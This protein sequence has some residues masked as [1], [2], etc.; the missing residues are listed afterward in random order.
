MKSCLS[1][2]MVTIILLAACSNKESI[3]SAD[4]V[5]TSLNELS[6]RTA[7]FDR[8]VL[9]VGEKTYVAIGFGLAN[10]IMIEGENS[11]VIIDAMESVQQGEEVMKVFREITQ[12]PI[13]KL[14]YTH[15]H[16]D[17]VFGAKAFVQ[18]GVTEVI[19]HESLPHYLNQVAS[20]VRPIIEKRS[21]RMFGNFLSSDEII[22]CGIG[23]HLEITEETLLSVVRPTR[24]FKDSLVITF[25]K[26]K[27]K[28]FHA[29]GETPDQ[30]F[31]YLEDEGIIF[32]GDNFY[33]TFPN[34]YTIRGTPYRDVN[35]W[36]SS[37]DHMRK[38][39]PNF[40][41]PS[42]TLPVEGKEKI[43]LTLR[44]YRDA[45][46][47]VHDQTIRYLN[48]GL[49]PDE[50]VEKVVLPQYL[51]EKPYLKEY[52]GK[53]E[54]S[55]RSI[56]CGYLGWFG[57]N[58]T[59]LAKPKILQRAKRLSALAGGEEQLF[60]QIKNAI[61]EQDYGWAMELLDHLVVLNYKPDEIKESR[62]LC[63][64]KLAEKESNPNAR[65]YYYTFAKELEGLKN[66]G[67]VTPSKAMVHHIPIDIVFSGMAV[68]LKAEKAMDI[69]KSITWYFPDIDKYRSI[70]IRNGVLE[71]SDKKLP[72]ADFYVEVESAI[73]KELAAEL[74]GS[75]K[76]VVSGKMKIMGNKVDFVKTMNLFEKVSEKHQASVFNQ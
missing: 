63:L 40:L 37:L 21:Y 23:K 60:T 1:I 70:V 3:P 12:K 57:G 36:V 16:T 20:I 64:E 62:I 33:N 8:Q 34:L 45:I 75:A 61:D 2:C 30:L 67:L 13:A 26:T 31:V 19:A 41:V 14:I 73:W 56:V 72:D 42:H 48:H 32:C 25:D 65:H 17:H 15:N 50:I 11:V 47:F 35:H 18:N 53:V 71:R 22:N 49:M 44:D 69:E 68:H 6:G 4:S 43:E 52:Y 29:P 38:F 7:Q 76:T 58:P 46:Q 28:L 55:V 10:S 66:H 54:W 27:L 39:E 5:R 9:K 74:I 51:S 59:E 24:T